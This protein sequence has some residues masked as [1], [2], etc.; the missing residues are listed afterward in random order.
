MFFP[1]RLET[2]SM[3]HNPKAD[4]L[5]L[6]NERLRT[7]LAQADQIIAACSA[8]IDPAP[9]SAWPNILEAAVARHEKRV[10]SKC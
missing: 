2:D 9:R 4:M 10:A 8:S 1:D 7:L 3:A 6:E 5:A